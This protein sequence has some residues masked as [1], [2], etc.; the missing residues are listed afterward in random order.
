MEVKVRCRDVI[1]IDAEGSSE[2]RLAIVASAAYPI[3]FIDQAILLHQYPLLLF[4]LLPG[5]SI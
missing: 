3:R 1:K 2:E 4:C 5:A